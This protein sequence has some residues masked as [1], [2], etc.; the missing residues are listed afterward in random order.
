[1]SAAVL[2]SIRPKWVELIA[3]GRKTV[4]MRKTRPKIEPP[5]QC[6][7]Y[8]TVGG[9]TAKE[10]DRNPFT[11]LRGKVI[12]E[13]VCSSIDNFS[14]ANPGNDI[15]SAACMTYEDMVHYFYPYREYLYGLIKMSYGWHISDLK[16]YDTPREL[17]EFR[18]VCRND[19]HCERCDMFC[20]AENKCGNAALYLTRP[21]QSW[22]YVEDQ[23]S[24][25]AKAM[26]R[27]VAIAAQ[28]PPEMLF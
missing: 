27:A 12:G 20:A 18:R 26:I 3:S 6:Y 14:V 19:L 7:I 5:F 15:L 16:I 23:I 8:C 24:V 25:L 11:D 28:I 10:R 1:M 4:E 21:P 2:V 22:C 17:I 9:T 13:F